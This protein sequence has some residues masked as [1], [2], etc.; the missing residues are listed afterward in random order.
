MAYHLRPPRQSLKQ[1]VHVL[2]GYATSPI[3]TSS[4]LCPVCRC[5]GHRALAAKAQTILHPFPA[6]HL[7]L[8]I[9]TRDLWAPQLETPEKA[10]VM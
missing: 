2:W 8:F 10:G 6:M 9:S 5:A 1:G 3:T 4:T 7:L